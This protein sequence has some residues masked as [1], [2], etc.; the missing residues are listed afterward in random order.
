MDIKGCTPEGPHR[1]ERNLR[2]HLCWP[3]ILT[4][5]PPRFQPPLLKP[6]S[7]LLDNHA[8]PSY[9]LSLTS[10]CT[11]RSH[12]FFLK[13]L[14]LLYLFSF[15][16]HS[17]FLEQASSPIPGLDYSAV[18]K[19]TTPLPVP[20]PQPGLRLPSHLGL[21]CE[22]S[23]HFQVLHRCS[24]T[25]PVR[26]INLLPVSSKFTLFH[27]SVKMNLGSS[28]IFPLL[29]GT[30]VLSVGV[31]KRHWRRKRGFASRFWCPHWAGSRST[32]GF[33]RASLASAWVPLVT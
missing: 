20:Q 8:S 19:M 17:L 33:S 28:D 29:V 15:G 9:L 6:T 21:T 13:S 2:V 32:R 31:L 25:P 27:C 18:F 4:W 11:Y 3:P 5:T 22:C 12:T 7:W 16:L 14:S 30:E 1:D 23:C 24:L 26:L 10:S